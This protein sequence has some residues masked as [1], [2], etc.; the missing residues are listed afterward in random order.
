[1]GPEGIIHFYP[2]KMLGA[3]YIYYIYIYTN[4]VRITHNA[5]YN[6]MVRFIKIDPHSSLVINLQCIG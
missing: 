5:K 6:Q 1:M 3:T 4:V 2:H